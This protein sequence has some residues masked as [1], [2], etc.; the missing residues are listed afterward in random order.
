MFVEVLILDALTKA[1]VALNA[2]DMF[3]TNFYLQMEIY[4]PTSIKVYTGTAQVTNSTVSFT[5][6]VP[7]EAS[8]GEYNIKAL[9]YQMPSAS[10]KVRI[11]N[12]NRE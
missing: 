1:P 11:R 10:R 4:D 3:F 12:Y 9:N 6:K 2:T 7:S 8:G 5:Y